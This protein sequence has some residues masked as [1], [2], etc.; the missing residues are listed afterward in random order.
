MSDVVVGGGW[1]GLCMTVA[2]RDDLAAFNGWTG[3][4]ADGAAADVH[5]GRCGGRPRL[6]PE[7]RLRCF[8]GT[9]A[10]VLLLA[11]LVDLCEGRPDRFD[12]RMED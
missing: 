3:G 12:E 4:V 6:E 9:L 8:E 10:W 11:C 1:P 2:C 7:R 5:P